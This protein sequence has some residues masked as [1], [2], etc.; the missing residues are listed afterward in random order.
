MM[1]SARTQQSYGCRAML[2]ERTQ[3]EDGPA[4]A[5]KRDDGVRERSAQL[6]VMA[7]LTERT[8]CKGRAGAR[9]R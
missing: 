1:R 2:V 7:I 3:C 9:E 5:P 6:T 4:A 8:Q